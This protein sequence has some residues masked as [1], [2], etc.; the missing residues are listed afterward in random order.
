M[1]KKLNSVALASVAALIAGLALL[2]VSIPQAALTLL[3]PQ[4]AEDWRGVFL[5]W[6]ASLLAIGWL[7]AFRARKIPSENS[8]LHKRNRIVLTVATVAI[9]MGVTYPT[10]SVQIAKALEPKWPA[11]LSANA[12][13]VKLKFS[14]DLDCAACAKSIGTLLCKQKGLEK[15]D[16]NI[17]SDEAVVWFNPDKTSKATVL[18]VLE[19]NHYAAQESK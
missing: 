17:E 8:K 2:F 15:A 9:L 16:F 18:Q 10:V 6:S 11:Q 7:L 3:S 5:T 1:K 19:Q 4:T 12:T 14:N 13:S